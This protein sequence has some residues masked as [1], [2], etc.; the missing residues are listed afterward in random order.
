[1]RNKLIGQLA[2]DAGALVAAT[3]NVAEDQ[4]QDAR[5]RVSAAIDHSMEIYGRVRGNAIDGTSAINDLVHKNSYQA[6]AIGIGAGLIIGYF[7]A[8]GCTGPAGSCQK[9]GKKSA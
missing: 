5:K 8:R 4:V 3:K 9:Q 2:Q 6:I 7:I 1:M